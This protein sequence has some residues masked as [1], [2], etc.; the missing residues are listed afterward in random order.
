MVVSLPLKV[1]YDV[2]N[3]HV[4]VAGYHELPLHLHMGKARI[5]IDTTTFR[6]PDPEGLQWVSYGAPFRM[7]EA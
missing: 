3:T 4:D 5:S 6:I 2:Q 7:F 1:I